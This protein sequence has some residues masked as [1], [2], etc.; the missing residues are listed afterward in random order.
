MASLMTSTEWSGRG[1]SLLTAIMLLAL[2]S[3]SSAAIAGPATA[4]VEPLP[5]KEAAPGVFV[6][7]G[8]YQL[9][10]PQNKG[11]VCNVSFVIG[12]EA[13]AVIDTG[14]S[15]HEGERLK[16][17]IRA[18]TA[19]PIRYVIDTH[20]HP[21]HVF[22]NAAFSGEGAIFIG[23]EKLPRALA[24][25]GDYYLKV[26]RALLGE[27]GIKGVEII[28]PGETVALGTPRDI[29]LGG[30]VLRLTA[31]PTAHTDNDLTVMDLETNTLFLGDLLFVRHIPALD[32]SLKGWL[33]ATGALRQ[34]KAARAVPGHGPA[35]VSWPEALAPQEKYLG[36][37]LARI[38]ELLKQG[39]DIE[40]AAQTVGLDERD[41]W[42]LFDEFNAR[43]VSAGYA[44]LEWE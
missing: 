3:A 22:G 28:P 17:A 9:F 29:D 19:L 8:A 34:V 11:A 4:A 40:Q 10:T 36:K 15:R 38:R 16:A 37:L 35:T 14:G 5:M 7:E 20:M 33:E 43:N 27:E 41:A 30:R 39:K 25:R 32:G 31:H 23:H 12:G 13:V 26:N 2:V 44:E 1:A 18:R 24:A 21:D 6:F 42:A